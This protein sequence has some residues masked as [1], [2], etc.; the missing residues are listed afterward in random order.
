MYRVD[1]KAPRFPLAHRF[2]A[3]ID[4]ISIDIE[5]SSIITQDH[6]NEREIA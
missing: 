5:A 4:T 1:D 2:S 6:V 3:I